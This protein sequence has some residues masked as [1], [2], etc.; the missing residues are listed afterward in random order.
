A[1]GCVVI[2]RGGGCA[3]AEPSAGAKSSAPGSIKGEV[4]G[5]LRN[6]GKG[7]CYYISLWSANSETRIWI[8]PANDKDRDQLGALHG[9]SVVASGLMYQRHA[10]KEIPLTTQVQEVPEGSFYMWPS[11]IAAARDSDP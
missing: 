7:D 3:L 2:V 4:T 1:R 9:K 8:L 10:P 6:T 11:K 5:L